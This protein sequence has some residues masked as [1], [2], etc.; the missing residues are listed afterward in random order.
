MSIDELEANRQLLIDAL[1][2]E[3]RGYIKDTWQPKE[4][5][6]V[7]CYTKFYLNLGSTAS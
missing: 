7:W 2:P 4:E 3:D 1:R 5:R 6:V